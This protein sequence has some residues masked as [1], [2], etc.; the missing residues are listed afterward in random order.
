MPTK[1][2]RVDAYIA[3]ASDFARPILKKIRTAVHAG[4]PG[5]SETIKWGVPAYVDEQGIVCMTA[6]FKRH[7]AWVFWSGRKPT[8]IDPIAVRRLTSV[9]D[10]PPARQM[11]A[12]VKEV[13]RRE[14]P[15]R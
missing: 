10:L 6:A 3:K 1:D 5:V 8:T 7:C 2:R 9:S 12:A 14:K 15:V 4:H 13:T 11:A